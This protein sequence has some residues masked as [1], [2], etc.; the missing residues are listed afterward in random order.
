MGGQQ[1]SALV[2]WQILFIRSRPLPDEH[3]FAGAKAPKSSLE[4]ILTKQ[5][6]AIV[7]IDSGRMGGRQSSALVMWQILYI[8]SRPLSDEHM[9]AGAKAPKS[10]LEKP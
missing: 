4:K 9:F 7:H 8:R 6:F 5:F 10:S 2:M 3:M 1:T